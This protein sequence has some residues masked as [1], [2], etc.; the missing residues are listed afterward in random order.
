MFCIARTCTYMQGPRYRSTEARFCCET[1]VFQWGWHFDVLSNCIVWKEVFCVMKLCCDIWYHVWKDIQW[2]SGCA[3]S[4]T[5]VS[6]TKRL[7][8]I[9]SVMKWYFDAIWLT[10]KKLNEVEVVQHFVTL[11]CLVQQLYCLE[12]HCFPVY[13][14]IYCMVHRSDA[15]YNVFNTLLVANCN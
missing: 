13:C 4:D 15:L 3:L 12:F 1:K 9:H 2:S 8:F 11:W 7:R 10:G 14:T 6:C 5:L